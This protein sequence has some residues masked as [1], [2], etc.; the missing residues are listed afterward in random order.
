MKQISNI[1]RT[2][3]LVKA[4]LHVIFRNWAEQF[5][6]FLAEYGFVV[7]HKEHHVHFLDN[8]EPTP[9][10]DIKSDRYIFSVSYVNR[11]VEYVD[12][13]WFETK[14][15]RH[16]LDMWD[17]KHTE[18]HISYRAELKAFFAHFSPRQ[19]MWVYSHSPKVVI[20]MNN[21]TYYPTPYDPNHV[22]RLFYKE[23]YCN[24]KDC[25]YAF[26]FRYTQSH[27][28]ETPA[29]VISE[30]YRA[31]SNGMPSKVTEINKILTGADYDGELVSPS[32][33]PL[34]ENL[35]CRKCGLPVFASA[36]RKY[37]FM[38]LKH[39]ELEYPD[40]QRVDPIQYQDTLEF[41]MEILESLIR[42]AECPQDSNL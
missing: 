13:Y 7:K 9:A 38:C 6:D 37:E 28:S 23:H 19:R 12:E 5:F 20:Q 22:E 33:T 27:T 24:F 39:G 34:S 10:P 8:S 1:E 16:L 4:R 18:S 35:L 40:V 32:K 11:K 25:R 36:E 14:K 15:G 17:E 3:Y 29:E 41:T 31:F 2:F 21:P 26:E 42:E 30:S